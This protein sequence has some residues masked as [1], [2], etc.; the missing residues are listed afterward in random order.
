MKLPSSIRVKNISCRHV[1]I[2]PAR[3]ASYYRY[4]NGKGIFRYV[5]M[6]I[7]KTYLEEAECGCVKR[8]EADQGSQIEAFVSTLLKFEIV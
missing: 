6:R 8:T 7:T 3:D 2:N 4:L 5:D 1:F